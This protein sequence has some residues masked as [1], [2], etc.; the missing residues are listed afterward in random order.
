M[1][2]E[3]TGT[4]QSALKEFYRNP[5]KPKKVGAQVVSQINAP[6][7]PA[8][9]RHRGLGRRGSATIRSLLRKPRSLHVPRAY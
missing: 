5:R 8:L 7:L 1:A 6:H 9:G 4:Y 2:G 3:T